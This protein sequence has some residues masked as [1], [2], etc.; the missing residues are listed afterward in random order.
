MVNVLGAVGRVWYLKINRENKVENPD[1]EETRVEVVSKTKEKRMEAAKFFSIKNGISINEA[2][3]EIKRRKRRK[4]GIRQRSVKRKWKLIIRDGELCFYCK[5]KSE[6]T[7]DH[8]VPLC[9]GGTG[10]LENLRL[11][12][13][14]CNNKKGRLS[15]EDFEFILRK[16]LK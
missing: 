4:D 6:I 2:L 3:A 1:D 16:E 15:N 12:C 5:S 9:D 7:V 13:R 8:I 14:G 10:R 11:V